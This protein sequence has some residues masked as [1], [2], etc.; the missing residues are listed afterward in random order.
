MGIGLL[1]FPLVEVNSQWMIHA[2]QGVPSQ[3]LGPLSGV[4]I[5]LPLIEG[6]GDD[7]EIGV[8]KE[9]TNNSLLHVGS[10][11]LRLLGQVLIDIFWLVPRLNQLFPESLGISL[12]LITFD[13]DITLGV[14]EVGQVHTFNV[15]SPLM[16]EVFDSVLGNVDHGSL[17]ETFFKV[18]GLRSV[19]EVIKSVLQSPLE[20]SIQDLT[21]TSRTVLDG[22]FLTLSHR[23]GGVVPV[24]EG[25]GQVKASH[26]SEDLAEL[27]DKLSVLFG[28]DFHGLEAGSHDLAVPF[29]L[30]LGSSLSEI[31]RG[32]DSLIPLPESF[33]FTQEMNIASQNFLLDS[34]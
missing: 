1:V 28:V 34:E 22:L 30:H 27:P 31:H 24:L 13:N 8:L 17:Q 6:F 25:S 33:S 19:L 32:L 11:L 4:Y 5:S 2:V 16:E 10:L 15:V 3:F 26:P 14:N 23:L 7:V 21:N 18:L 20:H 29:L 9:E 12:S